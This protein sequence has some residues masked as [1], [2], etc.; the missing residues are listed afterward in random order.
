MPFQR[1]NMPIAAI[2]KSLTE[3]FIERWNNWE[4]DKAV[5]FLK[6]DVIVYSPNI[7]LIYPENAECKIVGK[8]KVHD[9]W[10]ILHK[11]M[12]NTR[13]KLES[14]NKLEHEIYTISSISDRTEKLY[15]WFTYTEYGKISMLKFE[16]K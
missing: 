2:L 3:E 14:F 9:Y 12:S 10:N 16:Y 11:H 4:I 13:F 15:T 6:E 8:Q 7:K 1:I 5:A